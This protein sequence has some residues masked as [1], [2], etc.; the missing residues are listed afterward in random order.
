MAVQESQATYRDLVRDAL[1]RDG[2]RVLHAGCGRDKGEITYPARDR[3][4]IVG[5]DP[6]AE[7]GARFHS[8]FVLGSIEEMRASF[9]NDHF[10]VICCE[11]VIEHV[12]KPAAAFIEFGRVLK[13]GG[14]LL[15]QTPNFL[16]Y[17][18]QAAWMLPQSAHLALGRRRYGIAEPEM[19]PTLYRCNTG[20]ALVRAAA[21][22]GLTPVALL[23][24]NNGAT[25]LRGTPVVGPI[26]KAWHR[27]LDWPG[28][29]WARCTIVG[30]FSKKG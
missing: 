8:T 3:C 5:I 2:L 30:E 6:D 7:A 22:A 20:R 28:L 21:A 11:N 9:P 27:A 1:S 17:K 26:L 19:Y 12:G 29:A 4:E 13:A 23:Y 10:D 15:V 24:Q 14:R 25:W 16:S 18:A